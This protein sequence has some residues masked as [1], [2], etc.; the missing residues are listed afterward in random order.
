MIE[1]IESGWVTQAGIVQSGMG[2]LGLGQI[3][4][5]S[6]GIERVS[7]EHVGFLSLGLDV[8]LTL[9]T[10]SY[11]SFLLFQEG[12]RRYLGSDSSREAKSAENF[13]GLYWSGQCWSGQCWSGQYWRER[14]SNDWLRGPFLR[15]KTFS[16]EKQSLR[17]QRVLGSC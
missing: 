2:H 1:I 16:R 13:G 17:H 10:A 3:G 5:A 11:L 4:A 7:S 15:R 6:L 14:T 9:L 8:F 12:L